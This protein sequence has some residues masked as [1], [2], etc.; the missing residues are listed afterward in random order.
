MSDKVVNSGLFWEFRQGRHPRLK[1]TGRLY[2]GPPSDWALNTMNMYNKGEMV[3]TLPFSL[4]AVT[5]CDGPFTHQP[6]PELLHLP[7]S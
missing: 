5:V 4:Q 7:S 6:A 3:V 1:E 2:G